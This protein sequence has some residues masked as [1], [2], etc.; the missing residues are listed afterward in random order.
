MFDWHRLLADITWVLKFCKGSSRDLMIRPRCA[1]QVRLKEG[2]TVISCA[3]ELYE[4]YHY[5]C[6]SSFLVA[7]EC[8]TW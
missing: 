7:L 3:D 6:W 4:A 1:E 5:E 8:C 2:F